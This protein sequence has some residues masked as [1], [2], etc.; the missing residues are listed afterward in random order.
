MQCPR[1]RNINSVE[2]HYNG[3]RQF[4]VQ[5]CIER[6]R[7]VVLLRNEQRHFNRHCIKSHVKPLQRRVYLFLNDSPKAARKYR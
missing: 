6:R 3:A 2:G 7:N 4:F 1:V 5:Q